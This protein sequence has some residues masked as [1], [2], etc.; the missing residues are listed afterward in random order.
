[1]TMSGI[2]VAARLLLACTFSLFPSTFT[3]ALCPLPS[4]LTVSTL[5]DQYLATPGETS[6]DTAASQSLADIT[7]ALRRDGTAWMLARGA[8]EANHR[9]LIA[10][11]FA[12][13]VA[14]AGMDASPKDV[15]PLVEWGCEQVRRRLPS[16]AERAW[17]IAA[18]AVLE[19][20]GNLQAVEAHL[21]HAAIRVSTEPQWQQ[22][23]AWIADSKTLNVH[24][25]QPLTAAKIP[26]PVSLA[27]Q[28]EALTAV[29][30]LAGDA[31]TRIGFLHF[32]AG[33]HAEARA[34][35]ARADDA[36][37]GSTDARYLTHLFSAWI[38][39]REGRKIEAMKEFAAA[40]DATS[41]GRTAAVWL[42][43]RHQIDGHAA[44]AQAIV[45]RS[46][47]NSAGGVDPWRFFYRGDMRRWPLL[48]AAARRAVE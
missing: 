1:M 24:P 40:L 26:F 15:A 44:E 45:T 29:P 18:I 42:A 6:R 41:S 3:S 20:V 38:A 27:A 28:Y 23:R 4:A 19:G 8:G 35:F 25:R 34:S 32:L 30:A 46:L 43:S 7:A 17:Q 10:A 48:I 12:I 22:T 47:S 39:E 36:A 21:G 2:R 11:T 16:D 14:A 31:W 13:D 9:R 33:E 5:L 37:E